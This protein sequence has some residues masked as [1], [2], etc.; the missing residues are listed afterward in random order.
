M[1]RLKTE[2]LSCLKITTNLPSKVSFEYGYLISSFYYFPKFSVKSYVLTYYSYY[3]MFGI[4]MS[5]NIVVTNLRVD[6]NLW[7]QVKQLASELE[8]SAN[9]YI[10]YVSQQAVSKAFLGNS[11]RPRKDVKRKSIYDVLISLSKRKHKDKPMGLS[12]ED[13]IIYGV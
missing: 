9:E 3:G 6:K 13:K 7:L 2:Q 11:K 1:A 5:K 8:M 12:K 10:N 4:N